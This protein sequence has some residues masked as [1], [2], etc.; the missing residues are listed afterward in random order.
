MAPSVTI[1]HPSGGEL[2]LGLMDTAGC[3]C[4]LL[5]ALLYECQHCFRVS[6]TLTRQSDILTASIIQ[7][8]VITIWFTADMRFL[9]T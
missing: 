9:H 5:G 3:H 8:L 7:S 6:Y 4:M 2:A 1:C